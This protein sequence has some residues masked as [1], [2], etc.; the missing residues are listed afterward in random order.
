MGGLIWEWG[1]DVGGLD[2]VR[3]LKW[4]EVEMGGL[5]MGGTDMGGLI[6]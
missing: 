5:G 3:G 4:G 1:P 6:L 2:M